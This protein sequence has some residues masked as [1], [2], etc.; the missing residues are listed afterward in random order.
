[1]D[2]QI[3]VKVLKEKSFDPNFLVK[4]SYDDG[5]IRL[6]DELVSVS[7]RPPKVKCTYPE[8]IE[9]VKDSIDIKKLELEILRA[10]VESLLTGKRL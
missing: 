9:Q 6:K 10:I 5:N 7:R 3:S 2:L 8:S 1:L 4:V